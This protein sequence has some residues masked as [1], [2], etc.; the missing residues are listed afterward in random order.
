[1]DAEEHIKKLIDHDKV[2]EAI[3]WLN[4]NIQ[5]HPKDALLLFLR[6]KVQWN[7]GERAKAMNDYSASAELDPQGPAA[8]ALEHSRAIL[9]FFNPDLLNP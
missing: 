4:K 1:M 6:G 5:K 3:A 2:D 9:S 8:I 7:L